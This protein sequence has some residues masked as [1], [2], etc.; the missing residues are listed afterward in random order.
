MEIEGDGYRFV[1]D[2]AE[3]EHAHD[4][5]SGKFIHSEDIQRNNGHANEYRKTEDYK[6]KAQ[7]YKEFITGSKPQ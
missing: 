5:M 4:T 1:F 7:K 3:L 2:E 6:T